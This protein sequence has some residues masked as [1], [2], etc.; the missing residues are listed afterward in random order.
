MVPH[1]PGMNIL[2]SRLVL[3]AK[4]NT[5]SAIIKYKARLVSGGDAQVHGLHFDVSYAPVADFTVVRI[6]LSIS[7][8]E[9]R[10]VHSLN[11]SNAFVR[12]PLAKIVYVRPPQ[13][14]ADRFGSNVMIL[15]EELYVLNQAPLSWHSYM[16]KT[17]D[18]IK[19]IEAQS[20]CMHEYKACN[21]VVYVDDLIISGPTINETS[22]IEL[23]A[24]KDKTPVAIMGRT[25]RC[26]FL[27]RSRL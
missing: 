4:R 20:P 13:I 23:C 9:N 7:T 2:R 19:K 24:A 18:T 25:F 1:Q 5:A 17:F 26:N 6:I 15:N 8:C 14:L 27:R 11:V 22:S 16:E 21:I 10:V 12:A 3:N